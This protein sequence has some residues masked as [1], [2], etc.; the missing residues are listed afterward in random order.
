MTL[1]PKRE[2]TTGLRLPTRPSKPRASRP[3]SF[4]GLPSMAFKLTKAEKTQRGELVAQMLEKRDLLSAAVDVLNATLDEDRGRVQACLQDYNSALWDA[5]EFAQDI[6]QR[7]GDEAGE[8]SEQW[9]ESDRGQEVVAWTEEW[10]N[11]LQD[12]FEVEMP[13]DMT[14]DDMDHAETL[15]DLAETAGTE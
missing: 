8:K 9:Q 10:S 7:H 12:D 2:G 13:D 5:R 14:L 6:G 3:G 11:A 1:A 15:E 4:E